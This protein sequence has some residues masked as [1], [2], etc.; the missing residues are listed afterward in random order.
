MGFPPA[1]SERSG[2]GRVE[3]EGWSVMIGDGKLFSRVIILIVAGLAFAF[4]AAFLGQD[5]ASLF[6]DLRT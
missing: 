1:G 4:F 6:S 2:Y 3:T 5:Q